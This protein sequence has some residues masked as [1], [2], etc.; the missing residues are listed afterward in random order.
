[1]DNKPTIH[2]NLPEGWSLDFRMEEDMDTDLS[3]EYYELTPPNE[4]ELFNS[5]LIHKFVGGEVEDIEY[6]AEEY[7]NGL[8]MPYSLTPSLYK[9]IKKFEI[10]GHKAKYFVRQ[11]PLEV[12]AEILSMLTDPEPFGHTVYISAFIKD[13]EDGFGENQAI[14]FLSRVISFAGNRS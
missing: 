2:F 4:N 7:L 8:T 11:N 6:Y 14:E 9:F 3:F 12:S 13:W 5:I 10:D 1:M